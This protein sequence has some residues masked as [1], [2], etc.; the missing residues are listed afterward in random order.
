MSSTTPDATTDKK[1]PARFFLPSVAVAILAIAGLLVFGIVHTSNNAKNYETS[2]L[3]NA[4][5]TNV[6]VFH[7]TLD[8]HSTYAYVNVKLDCELVLNWEPDADNDNIG[9]WV[10]KARSGDTTSTPVTSA[11]ALVESGASCNH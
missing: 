10:Y 6:N 2:R 4:G 3:Q 9:H 5:F 1:D 8:K 11:A 7:S